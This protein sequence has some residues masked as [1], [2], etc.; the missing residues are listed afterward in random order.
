MTPSP[1]NRSNRS[2]LK[3]L[4]RQGSLP[5]EEHFG[6]LID[7]TLNIVDDGFSQ[8]ADNGVEITLLGQ[9]QRLLSFFGKPQDNPNWWIGC[10]PEKNSLHFA[11]AGSAGDSEREI[12]TMTS[13]GCLKVGQ[14]RTESHPDAKDAQS[15][16]EPDPP[17]LRLDVAGIVRSSGRM[18]VG[19]VGGGLVPADG[20][21]QGIT[22]I[23]TGC[24]AFEV[25]AGVGLKGQKKG[26]YA[27]LHAYAMNTFNP[28]GF[29]FNF[30]NLKNPIR[31]DHAW[32][33]SRGDRLKLRW[34]KDAECK[35]SHQYKLQIKSCSD[36]TDGGR[37]AIGIQYSL[38]KLWFDEAMSG[39]SP[40]PKKTGG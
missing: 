34:Y 27:L 8:S 6:D 26:R 12:L 39:S 15:Q 21:W 4:F 29:F 30:L 7:S 22:P 31:C 16:N 2:T 32:F 11:R 38:T 17:D 24:Q 19:V 28:R 20:Q 10:D 1:K 14:S 37:T 9:K 23:L 13:G 36:Y 5:T 33:L 35:E 3:K 25:M 40:S 18:G